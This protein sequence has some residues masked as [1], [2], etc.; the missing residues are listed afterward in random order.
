MSFHMASLGQ[1]LSVQHA[2]G[3]RFSA[4]QAK[5]LSTNLKTVLERIASMA[6]VMESFH[7]YG[8]RLSLRAYVTV[9]RKQ[10]QLQVRKAN[11]IVDIVGKTTFE[12]RL[13]DKYRLLNV[14]LD[15]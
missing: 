5:L 11:Q 1:N 10:L 8:F 15:S 3:T 14:H 12:D 9:T 6:S 2:P 13:A 7:R 4:E